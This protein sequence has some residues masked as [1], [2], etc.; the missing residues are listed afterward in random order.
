MPDRQTPHNEDR[1]RFNNFTYATHLRLINFTYGVLTE[2]VMLAN[3]IRIACML[4][5]FSGRPCEEPALFFGEKR[6]AVVYH[7][8]YVDVQH[9]FNMSSVYRGHYANKMK[10]ARK[11][12]VAILSPEKQLGD[13]PPWTSWY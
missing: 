3:A 10:A 2:V 13:L 1:W 5:N 8:T 7:T 9:D 11:I 4:L 12:A 6:L